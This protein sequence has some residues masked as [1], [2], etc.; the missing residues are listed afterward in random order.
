MAGDVDLTND[1]AF[2]SVQ[3]VGGGISAS[4]PTPGLPRTV[5]LASNGPFAGQVAIQYGLPK[6]AVIRLEVYDACGR[7]VQVVASG[8]GQAGYHT[9]VWKCTDEHGRA[10]AEGAYFVRLIADDVTLTSKV[11]KTE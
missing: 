3:V 5:T 4:D 7:R 9:E 11:V 10:V 6:S 8:A 2:D 1:A